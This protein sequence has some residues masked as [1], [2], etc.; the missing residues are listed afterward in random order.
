MRKAKILY[1]SGI[2]AARKVAKG[3]FKYRNKGI[4]QLSAGLISLFIESGPK[5]TLNRIKKELL[6]IDRGL[7]GNL[8][9]P[10]GIV[11]GVETA[12]IEKWYKHSH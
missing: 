2:K 3:D 11:T 10:N 4:V 8:V 12:A 6:A 7:G 1:R 9:F 5:N